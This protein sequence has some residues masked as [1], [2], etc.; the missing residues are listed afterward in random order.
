LGLN[1]LVN[2]RHYA[3]EC[4]NIRKKGVIR[5]I[6]IDMEIHDIASEH[7]GVSLIGRQGEKVK[8]LLTEEERKLLIER[9]QEKV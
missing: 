4:I 3:G 1:E 7:D 9:L 6:E 8:I 5:I 2:R